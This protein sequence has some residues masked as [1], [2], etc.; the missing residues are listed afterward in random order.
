MVLYTSV[1]DSNQ[2]SRTPD[3]EDYEYE[4]DLENIS[5]ET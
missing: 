1:W 2:N 4:D 5:L 3:L